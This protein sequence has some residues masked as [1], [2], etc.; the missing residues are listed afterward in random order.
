M[1]RNRNRAAQGGIMAQT[2]SKQDEIVALVMAFNDALNARD[3]DTM[4]SLMTADCVFENTA[5]PPD[6]S[7]YVGQAAV[8]AFWEGFFSGSAQARITVEEIFTGGRSPQESLE[9]CVMR[10]SY[11]WVDQGGKGGH[12]RG[13]DLYTVRCEKIAEKL[14]YVKG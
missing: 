13:V 5:P 12:I 11:H 4:M 14:S 6:G 10:W 8:R 3:L 9:R 2:S 1:K 7:R